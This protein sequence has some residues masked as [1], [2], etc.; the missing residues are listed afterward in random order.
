MEKRKNDYFELIGSIQ[1]KNRN[2]E[3]KI[4]KDIFPKQMHNMLT[5]FDKFTK[6]DNQKLFTGVYKY[7]DH[8]ISQLLYQEAPRNILFDT[9]KYNVLDQRPVEKKKN[10]PKNRCW[11]IH[12]ALNQQDEI[13]ADIPSPESEPLCDPAT[14]NI[15]YPILLTS[16]KTGKGHIMFLFHN[17]Y[18]NTSCLFDS[19][20]EYEFE[21]I[22]REILVNIITT[23]LN[24]TEV[25]IPEHKAFNC[26]EHYQWYPYD[27]GQCG[28]WCLLVAQYIY[29]RSSHNLMFETTNSLVVNE[30]IQELDRKFNLV[31]VESSESDSWF[32]KGIIVYS[33][34]KSL[35][36]MFR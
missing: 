36:K 14:D 19:N 34:A 8:L 6:K 15:Y 22:R 28:V 26:T 29:Y 1:V 11:C 17:P 21:S 10:Q 3:I 24:N 2:E 7:M 23:G 4:I 32:T 30:L 5:V 9:Y 13:I 27:R 16:N 12:I 35:A 25:H 33:Y 31:S 20:N 18:E